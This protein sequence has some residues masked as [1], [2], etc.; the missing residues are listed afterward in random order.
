MYEW[1]FVYGQIG[2]RTTV[3]RRGDVEKVKL[4]GPEQ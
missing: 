3:K 1:F 2:T 4:R